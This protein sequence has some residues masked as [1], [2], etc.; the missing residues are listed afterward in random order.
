[1]AYTSYDKYLESEILS[2]DPVKLVTI[3]Y[4]AA[5]DAIGAARKHLR[6]GAIRERSRQITKAWDLVYQLSSSLDHENGGEISRN[7]AS[8]YAYAQTRL[9]DANAQQSEAPLAE[10]EHL[11]GKLCDA[12]SEVAA[13][14][15]PAPEVHEPL[16][17]TY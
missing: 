5:I 10:V 12:W 9:L 13:R 2:A 16:S 1:M 15:A 6:E 11:L 7:L 8:L 3:L 17:C 14:Q 4:R